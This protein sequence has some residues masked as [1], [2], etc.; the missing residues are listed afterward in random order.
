MVV[1]GF[2]PADDVLK[3]RLTYRVMNVLRGLLLK[4]KVADAGRRRGMRVW[5]R[6]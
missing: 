6:P 1:K 4:G 3:K 5:S 2:D